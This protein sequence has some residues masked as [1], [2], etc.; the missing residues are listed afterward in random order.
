MKE[1]IINGDGQDEQDKNDFGLEISR[2]LSQHCFYPV[3][4]VHPC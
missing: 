4:P 3:Y 2:Q 1:E